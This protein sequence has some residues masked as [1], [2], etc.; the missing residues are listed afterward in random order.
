MEPVAKAIGEK[1]SAVLVFPNIAKTEGSG[2]NT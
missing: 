1:A 2:R